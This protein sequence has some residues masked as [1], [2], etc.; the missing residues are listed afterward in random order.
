MPIEQRV[1]S[2]QKIGARNPSGGVGSIKAAPAEPEKGKGK[3]KSKKK[4]VL[5]AG[6][7]VVLLAGAAAYW[8]L[9]GPGKA[10]SDAAPA[11]PPAPEAGVVLTVDPVSVN[12]SDGHYLRLGL[13]LQLTKDVAEAPDPAKALDLAIALYSGHT[14]AEVSDP[15]TRDALKAQLVT[16]LSDAYEGEV[17]DV[18]LTNFVTQ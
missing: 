7:V 18:Y 10:A 5:I 15:A 14:V 17:M 3:G 12:L 13:G 2:T 4:I 11:A 9:M 6:A 8:F 16:E 1:I